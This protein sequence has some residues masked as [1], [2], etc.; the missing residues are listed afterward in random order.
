MKFN[1]IKKKVL[2]LVLISS[3]S[4]VSCWDKEISPKES[5]KYNVWIEHIKGKKIYIGT[6]KGL[7][8][9][10]Y[11]AN[12]KIGGSKNPEWSYFCCWQKNGNKC[13]EQH[14]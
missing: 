14:K 13:Y 8:S 1:I 4:L 3:I 6:V 12:K 9:C 7:S 10:K 5:Y 2:L 11:I